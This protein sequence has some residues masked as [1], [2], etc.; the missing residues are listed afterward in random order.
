LEGIK[1]KSRSG[2]PPSLVDNGLMALLTAVY[3]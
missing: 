3:T 2:R 1:D